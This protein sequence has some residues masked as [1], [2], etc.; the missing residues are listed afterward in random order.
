MKL[1]PFVRSDKPRLKQL[2][3]KGFKNKGMKVL[4]KRNPFYYEPHS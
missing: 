1:L 3:L 2:C 4:L